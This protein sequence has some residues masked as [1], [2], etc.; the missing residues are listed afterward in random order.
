LILDS[1]EEPVA[2]PED[3]YIHGLAA[4]TTASLLQSDSGSSISPSIETST[5]K[6]RFE[7]LLNSPTI[8]FG[9]FSPGL[10]SLYCVREA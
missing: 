7:N 10:P 8:D 3:I 9:N 6:M 4:S 2:S 1:E 5:R